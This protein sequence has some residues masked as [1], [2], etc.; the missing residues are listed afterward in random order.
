MKI[1]LE[2]NEIVGSNSINSFLKELSKV[3]NEHFVADPNKIHMKVPSIHSTDDGMYNA[4]V[5]VEFETKPHRKYGE[6]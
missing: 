6:D 1:V 5:T 3:L 4:K 2:N